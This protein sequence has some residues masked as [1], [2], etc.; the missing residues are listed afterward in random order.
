MERT[1]RHGHRATLARAYDFIGTQTALEHGMY[2]PQLSTTNRPSANVLQITQSLRDVFLGTFNAR[3]NRR[4][5]RATP[6]CLILCSTS[7]GHVP[8]EQ[9]TGVGP[10]FW[11][12]AIRTHPP[13]FWC[14]L[15]GC[16]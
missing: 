12:S 7:P 1:R 14:T 2:K 10:Q 8:R 6:A 13:A 16:R 4:G 5:R 3:P 9:K 15:V 11:L